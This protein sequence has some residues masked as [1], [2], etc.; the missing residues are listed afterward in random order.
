MNWKT[1]QKRK[2]VPRLLSMIVGLDFGMPT[3]ENKARKMLCAGRGAAVC[4]GEVNKKVRCK[5]AKNAALGKL[6]T[7]MKAHGF[8]H[9]SLEIVLEDFYHAATLGVT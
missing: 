1:P 8:P 7:M 9:L 4:T 5:K 6:V 3:F 2:S